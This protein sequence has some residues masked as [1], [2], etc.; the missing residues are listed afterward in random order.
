[1]DIQQSQAT[2][3]NAQDTTERME[4]EMHT[5][6]F[7]LKELAGTIQLLLNKNY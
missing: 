6:E 7:R 4:Q 5:Y 1:M 2:E 3:F